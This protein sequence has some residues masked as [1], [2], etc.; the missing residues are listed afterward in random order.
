MIGPDPAQPYDDET[1]RKVAW[2]DA[3]FAA[4]A[5]RDWRRIWHLVG[6]LRLI[7]S[8]ARR[9]KVPAEAVLMQIDP[10][11]VAG[12]EASYALPFSFAIDVSPLP[13]RQRLRHRKMRGKGVIYLPGN[14]H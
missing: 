9:H 5:E 12:L 14:L 11:E 3:F 6:M 4:V 13:R 1:A 2:F 7:W 8:E 10:A